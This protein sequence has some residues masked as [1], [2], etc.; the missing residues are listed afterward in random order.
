MKEAGCW[1]K[2]GSVRRGHCGGWGEKQGMM[3][4]IRNL[5]LW[6]FTST[7][8]CNSLMDCYMVITDLVVKSRMKVM[9]EDGETF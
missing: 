9:G 3:S 7:L 1:R 5:S 4:S 6:G 2:T 8:G